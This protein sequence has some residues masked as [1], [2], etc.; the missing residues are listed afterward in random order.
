MLATKQLKSALESFRTT[1]RSLDDSNLSPD[2]RHKRQLD[3]EIMLTMMVKDKHI[4]NGKAT[5][6]I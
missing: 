3:I 2:E 4:K 6:K 5:I 1:M